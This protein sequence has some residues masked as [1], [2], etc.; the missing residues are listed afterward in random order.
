M[1]GVPEPWQVVFFF[2]EEIDLPERLPDR[3]EDNRL[4]AA[5]PSGSL[6][7]LGRDLRAISLAQGAAV[8]EPGAP[9]EEIYFPQTGMLSLLVVDRDGR[10]IEVSTVGREG[11]VGLMALSVRGCRSHA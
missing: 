5:L 11:A 4:L 1:S 6:D 3:H 10:A 9:I 2:Y 7:L 8:Y